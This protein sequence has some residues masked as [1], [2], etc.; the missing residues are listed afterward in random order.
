M[1]VFITWS[2]AR[3]KQ[4]AQ[5][6]AA[7]VRA[8]VQT[9]KP[10]LSEVDIEKGERWNEAVS[11][12]LQESHIGIVCLTPENLTAPWIHFEA[13]ALAKTGDSRVCVLLFEVNAAEVPETLSQFQHTLVSE[14][15]LA[16]LAVTINKA[17]ER[18]GE[19]AAPEEVI[20]RASS[21]AWPELQAQA[22]EL[23][24]S[25][26]QGIFPIGGRKRYE[27]TLYGIPPATLDR[28]HASAQKQLDFL[29]HSLTGLFES[30]GGRNGILRALINGA[31]VRV[32]FLDPTTPH[33]DQLNQVGR[34]AKT[35]LIGKINRSI[36]TAIAFKGALRTYLRR[37]EPAGI[38]DAE[39]EAAQERL[40]LAASGLISYVHI[41]RV[42][43]MML[44]SH[45][46]Q[47]EDPGQRA[48]TQEFDLEDRFFRFYAEEFDRFWRDATPV[49]ELR[50]SG[51]LVAD[52]AR[53]VR[54]LP[55][56]QN[57]YRSV[58]IGGGAE[59][60]PPPRMFVVLPNMACSLK[61]P[62]CFTWNSD[63]MKGRHMSEALFAS[64]VAQAKS[65]EATCVELTGGGEPLEHPLAKRLLALAASV[66]GPSLRAGVLSNAVPIAEGRDEQLLDAL[67]ALDYLRLGWTE[68]Y[69]L[70]P[71]RYRPRF[72]KT[73]QAI[74]DRRAKIG[75]SLRLGVKL[76]LTASN[77][78]N[79]APMIASLLDMQSES[80]QP[81]VNHVKVKSIRGRAD[82][83]PS[84]NQVRDFE[85][86]MVNLKARLG[87]RADDVQ[88]D[89]K[90]ARVDASYQCWIS[91]LM[92]VIDASGSVYLCCNFYE[93]P[94][95]SK[96]GDLGTN[97]EGNFL[98]FWGKDRHRTVIRNMHAESVCNSPLGCHCR[99]VHYQRLIEPYLPYSDRT[100]QMSAPLFPGHEN[101][102]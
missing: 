90:S 35:D 64:I 47:S 12:R 99:L 17:A 36:D 77:L 37:M 52:R 53:V 78:P 14:A 3:S 70:D 22:K 75:S 11:T 56:L 73:I 2:G 59:P 9:S 61:C 72:L 23:A 93:R 63:R 38:T 95:A 40:K 51:G 32:I 41:Q 79:L 65:L 50:I 43:N 55:V 57:V 94:E 1:Q 34:A 42:D 25:G 19:P 4:L 67:L 102:L 26:S 80:G 91:P 5:A 97:G 85:H 45:Y 48:P 76:L 74:G 31:T 84:A 87:A 89:V 46:S 68:H 8:A 62:S 15:D 6:V 98:E 10:W 24:R 30:S 83:E 54:H 20:R 44:V 60:L 101:M 66:K 33:S 39:V 86:A 82:I 100:P 88:V 18:A 81:V 21:A 58:A 16:N 13:G 49:E 27:G 28:F 71:D 7:W 92:T 29:G 96:I 69:D